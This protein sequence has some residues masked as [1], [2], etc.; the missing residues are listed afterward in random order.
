MNM[1]ILQY[2]KQNQRKKFFKFLQQSCLW[3]F[4][5]A[6]SV[7]LLK[8]LCGMKPTNL[9]LSPLCIFSCMWH[10]LVFSICLILIHQIMN[11]ICYIS[12]RD[13]M[14]ELQQSLKDALERK[15]EV[16]TS[17]VL[18]RERER[19]WGAKRERGGEGGRGYW[20]V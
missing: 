13:L 10:F 15:Q 6:H 11:L 7:Y 20:V 4:A 9:K 18:W 17:I 2:F 19:E 14:D 16:S 5:F 3:K 1:N 12:C 8:L